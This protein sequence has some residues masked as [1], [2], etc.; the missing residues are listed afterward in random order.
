VRPRSRVAAVS[1]HSPFILIEGC[2]RPIVIS[3]GALPYATLS[4]L[5]NVAY[6]VNRE[7]EIMHAKEE[8][9]VCNSGSDSPVRRSTL[10]TVIFYSVSMRPPAFESSWP[11]RQ[12]IGAGNSTDDDAFYSFSTTKYFG[13]ELGV[14]SKFDEKTGTS[15]H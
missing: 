5:K 1:R 12:N 3:T 10:L 9:K 8:M 14:Q 6:Y 7:V 11:Y 13:C 4:K 15:P 2:N